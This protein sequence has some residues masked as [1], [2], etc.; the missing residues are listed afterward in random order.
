MRSPHRWHPHRWWFR[1]LFGLV[2][3]KGTRGK[4][5]EVLMTWNFMSPVMVDHATTR[6][7]SP[8]SNEP[9]FTQKVGRALCTTVA[10]WQAGKTSRSKGAVANAKRDDLL[11]VTEA[12]IEGNIESTWNW[13]AYKRSDTQGLFYSLRLALLLVLSSIFIF[14]S[15]FKF[16]HYILHTLVCLYP[17]A[18]FLCKIFPLTPLHP[19]NLQFHSSKS[20]LQASAMH[21]SHS[22]ADL[23]V[24]Q[25]TM[26]H[27]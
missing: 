17:N 9:V 3:S 24:V 10:Q 5:L 2:K 11:W 21:P 16:Y 19:L 27:N 13:K 1:H 12:V 7:N 4:N 6:F 23:F 15:V 18:C 14:S 8:N 26:Q 22:V 20:P 25:S